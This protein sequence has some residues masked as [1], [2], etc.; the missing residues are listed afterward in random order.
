MAVPSSSMLIARLA[1][2]GWANWSAAKPASSSRSNRTS[3]I[4]R[5]SAR[6]ILRPLESVS[7]S[8]AGNFASGRRAGLRQRGPVGP[9]GRHGVLGERPHLERVHAVREPP[10]RRAADLRRGGAGDPRELRLVEVRPP[11]EHFALRQHVGLPAEPADP[12]H[13]ANEPGT[14]LRLGALQLHRRGA[15]GEQA[16]Q[17][18]VDRPFDPGR[19]DARADAG[20]DGEEP[21]DLAQVDRGVHV[22]GDLLV[23]DQP[24]EQPGGLAGAERGRR[25]AQVV[26]VG[27]PPLGHVP[28]LVE[29]GLRDAILHDA[30]LA[31]GALGD[32]GLLA[33]HRRA[34]RNVAEIALDLGFRGRDVDVARHDQDG[35]RRA[36]V[37]L[38]PSFTSS[39]LAASRS[40][41]EP[42]TVHE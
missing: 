2:P 3:G 1:V 36:V 6:T 41:I 25:E 10:R 27:R 39:S 13:A 17:L 34:R 29:P 20:L 16:G 19:I 8:S 5:R 24:L 22:G 15:G 33:R 37:R 31:A 7:R 9:G 28:H 14:R 38:E 23:V 40:S 30:A 26:A 4:D 32:P 21:A 18:L 11:R 42:M 12:L 35:V